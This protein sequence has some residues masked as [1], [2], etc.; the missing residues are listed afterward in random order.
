MAEIQLC[1]D[2]GA[3]YLIVPP[4]LAATLRQRLDEAGL[5]ADVLSE[6]PPNGPPVCVFRFAPGTVL[7]PIST[8]L[9]RYEYDWVLAGW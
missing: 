3:P 7:P 6:A 5:A 8:L 2:A 9:N 1:T 4:H